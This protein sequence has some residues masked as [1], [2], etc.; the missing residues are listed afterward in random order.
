M[1]KFKMRHIG[2]IIFSVS[3]II[4]AALFVPKA[5]AITSSSNSE[6]LKKT[7]EIRNQN[8]TSE[9]EKAKQ[10][11]S[12][13]ESQVKLYTEKI[14]VVQMQIDLINQEIESKNQ[15]ITE[16]DEKIKTIQEKIDKNM[17]SL[18]RRIRAI[19]VSG[20]ASS[21][22]IILGADSVGDL[23]D[24]NNFIK[25]MS[26]HDM[27]LINSLKEQKS[28]I[29]KERDSIQND[30]QEI[31]KQKEAWKKQQDELTTLLNEK[32]KLLTKIQGTE[33]LILDHIDS[34]N[35]DL[36]KIDEKIKNYY[37]SG[38][39]ASSNTYSITKS[40]GMF[41]W[42]IQCS[43]VITSYWG[44]GR[45]HQG[46]D[47]SGTNIYGE[48]IIAVADGTVILSNDD[49]Y[50]GGYGNYVVLDHGNGYS[51]LY[52]HMSRTNVSEGQKVKRGETIGYVG[53][54]GDSTGPHLHYEVRINGVRYDPLDFY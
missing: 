15:R 11:A 20:Q 10:N 50:G 53:N 18:K 9:L 14:E 49:G 13:L 3:V 27:E 44:D 26:A 51:T 52:A 8:L 36:K 35:E 47:I 29:E 46:I 2:I 5:L 19:Y 37:S 41:A 7:L 33:Q 28:M 22:D 45:N 31:L 42:P 30:K 21:W 12:D 25:Y 43:T 40:K 38:G 54:T 23:I 1:F 48:P 6:T 34:N 39:G 16:N 17:E 32:Q 4:F 24:K